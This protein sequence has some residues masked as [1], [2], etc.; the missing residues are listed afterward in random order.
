MWFVFV[1]EVDITFKITFKNTYSVFK[2]RAYMDFLILPSNLL[3]ARVF[4]RLILKL[5]E[6]TET[7]L[8]RMH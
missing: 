3:G 8:L 4:F 2:E 1:K 6:D 7:Q 5:F